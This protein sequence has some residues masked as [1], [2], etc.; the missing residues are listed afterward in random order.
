MSEYKEDIDITKSL[1][2]FP[3]SA[4][5]SKVSDNFKKQRNSKLQKQKQ[6]TPGRLNLKS[7]SSNR[8]NRELF[9]H[10][11]N[12]INHIEDRPFHNLLPNQ[13][14]TEESKTEKT[15]RVRRKKRMKSKSSPKKRS[16]ISDE[17]NE[18]CKK[19]LI[20]CVIFTIV[21]TI[22]SYSNI[23]F[24]LP[25]FRSFSSSRYESLYLLIFNYSSFHTMRFV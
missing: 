16:F 7:A 1:R 20:C 15:G 12:L 10:R 3:T 25:H 4:T 23:K 19:C 2:L 11:P 6:D 13:Q 9:D 18:P 14:S 5:L 8:V 22:I 17:L 21:T 24:S